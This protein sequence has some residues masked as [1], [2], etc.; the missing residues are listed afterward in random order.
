M[1]AQPASTRP[2]HS[3]WSWWTCLGRWSCANSSSSRWLWT[4]PVPRSW[5]RRPSWGPVQWHL[6]KWKSALCIVLMRACKGLLWKAK[7]NKILKKNEGNDT[8]SNGQPPKCQLTQ[9]PTCQKVNLPKSQ[10][11]KTSTCQ[12]VNLYIKWVK[13][14]GWCF[15]ISWLFGS[16]SLLLVPRN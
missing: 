1:L 12:K 7:H 9:K 15:L 4:C 13:C 5:P 6:Y 11:A 14:S 8:R 16:C 3:G 2:D 10:L